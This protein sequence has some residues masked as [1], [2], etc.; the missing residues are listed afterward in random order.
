MCQFSVPRSTDRGVRLVFVG[1]RLVFVGV[2][3]VREGRGQVAPYPFA[4]VLCQECD[5]LPPI[6]WFMKH[7]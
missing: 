6:K 4:L 3:L 7:D 1:V 5:D 2:R